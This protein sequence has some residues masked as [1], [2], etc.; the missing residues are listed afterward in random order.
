LAFTV[1]LAASAVS[2]WLVLEH[3]VLPGRT[4]HWDEASH[5]LRGALIVHDLRELDWSGL[6]IDTYLQVYWPPLHSWILAGAF[7]VAGQSLEVARAV[8]VLAFVLLAP[9]LFLTGRIVAPRHGILAGSIAAGLAL[10]SPGLITSAA[11]SMLELPGLLAMSM[12]MLV[13]CALEQGREGSPR[14]HALLGLG[15]V[16]TYLVKSNYGILLV[17]GIVLTRLIDVDFR[18]R[19]L[20]TKKN[21]YAVLPLAIF[22]VVWFAYPRKVMWTW[23]MLVNLPW[24]GEV[25]RGVRGLV[26]FPRVIVDY[27]GSLW[28]AA[29]L[30]GG[31]AHA[32]RVR[33]RPGISLLVVVPITLLLIGTFHHTKFPRHILPVFPP[34]FVLT[35]IA[36]AELWASLRTRGR[37]M[38]AA[39]IGGLVGLGL[40]QFW[41]IARRDWFPRK[42][43]TTEV[44]DY[45][46]E[47]TRENLP[48]L[49]LGTQGTKPTPP[50]IDWHLTAVEELL[51]VTAAGSVMDSYGMRRFVSTIREAPVPGVVRATAKRVGDRY[52]EASAARSLHVG[53]RSVKSRAQFES[54]LQKTLEGRGPPRS[55]VTVVGMS[56]STRY[57]PSFFEPGLARAG[58]REVSV[59]EF[60]LAGTRVY[61]Y[62][63]P[64]VLGGVTFD[65]ST[66]RRS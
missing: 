35:G 3:F 64:H 23:N 58:F 32:W 50:A 29:A 57:P 53:Y 42:T 45:V 21:L 47:L 33:R 24:G 61:L 2:G 59:R 34:L 52:R 4:P 41:T 7:L 13:Y 46:S 5:A 60:P 44:L 18:V 65:E 10:T 26:Y 11:E 30:W 14:A 62:S 12:T 54:A 6:L 19:R 66:L 9:T 28:M 63:R 43:P 51:P 37:S 8:S 39:A 22:C 49:V 20:A 15:T 27:A 16:V 36:G 1:V 31:L 17:I 38:R 40:L 56:D 25:T 48:V 55:V